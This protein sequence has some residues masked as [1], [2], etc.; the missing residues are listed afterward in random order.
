M[1]ALERGAGSPPHPPF[2]GRQEIRDRLNRA[3]SRWDVHDP[4]AAVLIVGPPGI[5]KTSLLEQVVRDLRSSADLLVLTAGGDEL[6]AEVTYGVVDQLARRLPGSGSSPL[7]DSAPADVGTWLLQR[8]DEAADGRPIVVVVDDVQQ[9]DEASL[10]ALTFAVRRMATDRFALILATRPEGVATVPVGLMRVIETSTGLIE[11]G[12]F[13]RD[14]VAE[15]SAAMGRDLAGETAA[16]IREHTG[17]HPLHTRIL[18]EQASTNDLESMADLQLAVPSLPALVVDR[19]VR[20]SPRA[21]ALLDAL[22]LL[23]EPVA[24]ADAAAVASVDDPDEEIQ[25]LLDL[26]LVRPSPSWGRVE[27]Q[28]QL[29]RSAVLGAISVPRRNELHR[30]AAVRTAGA[31]SLRHRVA[32]ASSPDEHL[33]SDLMAQA[34]REAAQGDRAQ[35]AQWCFLAGQHSTGE[36][37]VLR[38][39]LGADHLLSMG[40]PLTPWIGAIEALP[41]SPLQEAILGRARITEGRFEE[42]A[43]LLERAW[44]ERSEEDVRHSALWARVAEAMAII[45]VSRLDPDAVV[46]WSERLIATGTDHLAMTMLCHGLALRGDIDGAFDAAT[47]RIEAEGLGEVDADAR[48]GRGLANLWSNRVEAA[49]HDLRSVLTGPFTH[50]LLEELT[51]RSHLADARYREGLLTEAAD[52][53]DLAIELVEHSEAVWLMPLP[54]SIA[55]YAHTALGDLEQARHHAEQAST[56]GRLTGEAPAVMWSEAAWLRIAEAADD[57]AAVVAAGDR[58]LAGGLDRV[59]EGIN[60]WRATYVEGLVDVDRLRDAREV[61]TDLVRDTKEVDDARVATGVLR[62]R[63]AV[64]AAEGDGDDAAEAYESGLAIEP[65]LARPLDRAQLELA[66]GR[67]HR[68]SGD[69]ARGRVLLEAAGER[70]GEIGARGWHERCV[71]ELTDDEDA[72]EE[73]RHDVLNALTPRE[74]MVSRLV[75]DGRSNQQVA[76]EL[77]LSVKTVEHHLS[78]IYAKLGVQSRTQMAAIVND[79]G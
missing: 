29:L 39:L 35:A 27:F 61:L 55:A 56:Y 22:A 14:D 36:D 57:P 75:A 34:E 25:E 73:P 42:A 15:L 26:G 31:E 52:L 10:Q 4:A 64:A 9:V 70:F 68:R 51:V 2:V 74:R 30:L 24:V 53:A 41:P 8:F 1:E 71:R 20:C 43:V 62:A 19:L 21:R 44:A 59:P 33:A 65:R 23:D 37:R 16:K 58:M 60:S 40:R 17:G 69:R 79:R 63:A 47:E 28:H 13:G 49:R 72:L 7:R 76:A 3:L 12:G 5:G 18:L 38:T 78:S 6:E 48:L 50:S 46:E 54:H 11:L 45:G 66:A 32:V 77:V 67:F